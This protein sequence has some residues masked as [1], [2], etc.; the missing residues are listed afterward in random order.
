VPRLRKSGVADSEVQRSVSSLRGLVTGAQVTSSDDVQLG[1]VNLGET[2][3][4]GHGGHPTRTG[5]R[6]QPSAQQSPS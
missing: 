5:V 2:L 1:G 6:C 4:S 3:I